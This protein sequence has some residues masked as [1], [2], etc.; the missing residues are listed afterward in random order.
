MSTSKIP[1]ASSSHNI[2]Q[3]PVQWSVFEKALASLV[4]SEGLPEDLADSDYDRVKD[5]LNDLF[6][7]TARTAYVAYAEGAKGPAATQSQAATMLSVLAS[8]NFSS[9]MIR[10]DPIL[11]IHDYIQL[12]T[13]TLHP[14][15]F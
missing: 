7:V 10:A 3:H 12:I 11:L 8:G 5:S 14:E 9:S 15:K 1:N 13:G 6:R 4:L 2:K